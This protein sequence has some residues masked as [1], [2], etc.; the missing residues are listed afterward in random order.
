VLI[1]LLFLAL[2]Q[3]PL[4]MDISCIT[5][6]FLI[7]NNIEIDVYCLKP[8]QLSSSDIDI[9]NVIFFLFPLNFLRKIAIFYKN[10]LNKTNSTLVYLFN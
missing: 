5:F 7:Y 1:I 6:L 3:T 2:V 10:K 9:L 8:H 4:Q